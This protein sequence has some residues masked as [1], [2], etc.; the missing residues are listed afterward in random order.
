MTRVKEL[1][2][3]AGLTMYQLAAQSDATYATVYK[4]CTNG[5]I[6]KMPLGT[7][8][9]FARALGLSLDKFY[10]F[11]LAQK[12]SLKEGWNELEND[13]SVFVEDGKIMKGIHEGN[14]VFPYLPSR[15]GGFQNA[16]GI[17]IDRFPDLIWK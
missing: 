5:N 3:A 14:E 11:E 4:Y 15:K 9:K 13:F 10:G 2:D 7:A 17:R 8:A 1:M 6:D 16:V 12:S